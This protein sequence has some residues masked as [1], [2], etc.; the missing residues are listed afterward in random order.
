MAIGQLHDSLG[1]EIQDWKR[2]FEVADTQ[3]R[4]DARY[5]EDMESELKWVIE[6]HEHDMQEL[7]TEHRD[8]LNELLQEAEK[9][10]SHAQDALNENISQHQEIDQESAEKMRDL[11]SKVEEANQELR[12]F[13]TESTNSYSALQAQANS[14]SEAFQ[15]TFVT[16]LRTPYLRQRILKLH[17]RLTN[18]STEIK[19]LQSDYQTREEENLQN[20]NRVEHSLLEETKKR[21]GYERYV[22]S[23]TSSKRSATLRIEELER[24]LKEQ[25][26]ATERNNQLVN[27]GAKQQS[28]MQQHIKHLRHQVSQAR[29]ELNQ[30]QERAAEQAKDSLNN[31]A[32]ELKGVRDAAESRQKESSDDMTRN[33]A[34]GKRS[35]AQHALQ[36][37]LG[38]ENSRLSPSIVDEILELEISCPTST[39]I[40]HAQPSAVY[41][42]WGG[43]SVTPN[44]I[45]HWLATRLDGSISLLWPPTAS[46][47]QMDI[48]WIISASRY[49]LQESVS[50][51]AKQLYMQV[52]LLGIIKE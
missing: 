39:Y 4:E 28:I 36:P 44:P 38:L 22:D 52:H 46:A 47:W 1:F 33:F 31:H 34:E 20:M 16:F 25:R 5:L 12:N 7:S 26:T 11:E 13:Q 30:E 40:T 15:C 32:T 51:S 45:I 10:A 17:R 37:T 23:I 43:Q 6:M 35:L 48:P 50:V 21:S 9:Q 8:R 24:A 49:L 19:L 29:A 27:D 41:T 2:K 3:V 14:L 18:Q 42:C